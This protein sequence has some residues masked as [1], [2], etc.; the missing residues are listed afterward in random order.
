MKSKL[1]SLVNL[2][3]DPQRF[4]HFPFKNIKC[5]NISW[6]KLKCVWLTGVPEWIRPH[7]E[8]VLALFST[9]LPFSPFPPRPKHRS[10]TSGWTPAQ[11]RSSSIGGL[12]HGAGSVWTSGQRGAACLSMSGWGWDGQRGRRLK[13]EVKLEGEMSNRL[14]CVACW[15]KEIC[16]FKQ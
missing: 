7:S 2:Q 12:R 5:S 9:P 8:S 3:R 14:F 6:F 13:Q 10:Q 1:F 16:F 11:H 4:F 15:G